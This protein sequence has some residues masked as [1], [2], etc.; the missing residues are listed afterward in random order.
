M[1]EKTIIE[2]Y[3]KLTRILIDNSL[4]VSTME[5]CTGGLVGV[6]LSDASGASEV[7]RGGI[8]A[9]TNEIKTKNGVDAAVINEHGVYS[10]ETA[11]AMAKAAKKAFDSDIGIGITGSMGRTDPAN[12]DSVP[13]E[14]Y[15]GIDMCGDVVDRLIVVD[16]AARY[17]QRYQVADAICDMLLKGGL[18]EQ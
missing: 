3:H 11:V 9:Y 6:L 13:G 2:K 12:P 16:D 10:S 7:V 8:F 17:D 18:R 1:N 14:V 15:V 5:S 4:T